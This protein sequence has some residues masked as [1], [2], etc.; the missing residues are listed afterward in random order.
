[1]RSKTCFQFT[2][3]KISTTQMNKLQNKTQTILFTR[4]TVLVEVQCIDI[5]RRHTFSPSDI[6]LLFF[7]STP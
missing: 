7:V 6:F 2:Y 4:A 5:Y 1:M 3:M